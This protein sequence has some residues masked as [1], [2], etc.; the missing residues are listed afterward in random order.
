M[1]HVL[2]YYYY[3]LLLFF[4]NIYF[5]AFTEAKAL[6]KHLNIRNTKMYFISITFTLFLHVQSQ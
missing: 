1:V 4:L 2:S 3:S 6:E 5:S